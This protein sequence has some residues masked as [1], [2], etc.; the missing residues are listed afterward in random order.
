MMNKK[1]LLPVLA[2]LLAGGIYA[3]FSGGDD[4]ASDASGERAVVS[5]EYERGPNRGRMLRKDDFALE[6]TIFE[7]GVPPEY[8]VY[9]YENDKLVDPAKVQM[10]LSLYRLDGEVNTFNFTPQKDFLKGDGVVTEPHSFDVKVQASYNGENHNWEFASYEGRTKIEADS[11][12]ASGIVIERVGPA[13]IKETVPLTGRIVLNRNTTA[14]VKARFP[15]VIRSVKKEQG[16]IVNAGDVMAT[17]ESNDSLQVYSITSPIK[18]VVI[19]RSANIGDV[20]GDAP[21][22]VVADLSDVWAEFH[23][24]PRDVAR[25][26]TGQKV[27]VTSME[28]AINGEGTITALLPLTETATQTVVARVPIDNSQGVWRSGMTVQGKAVVKEREVPLAVKASG[29]QAFRDFTV[30][31]A[32]IGE[33]YEVRMLDLGLNDGEYVEVLGGI[34]PDTPYVSENSFLIKADIEKSGASHDH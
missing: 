32:Q 15:G 16:E 3:L 26:Q 1:L 25:V 34:K 8:H 14:N 21:L 31:F 19:S 28:N 27:T 10:T 6:I 20:A 18:G 9:A 12:E 30:V 22:F 5:D 4:S 24:F 17:V 23:V 33:T 29:L 11:A 13:T 7:D 2:V